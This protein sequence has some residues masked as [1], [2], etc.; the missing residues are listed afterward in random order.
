MA[1][2]WLYLAKGGRIDAGDNARMAEIL[3]E[4]SQ[5]TLRML[6]RTD[7]NP[8][9]EAVPGIDPK[10]SYGRRISK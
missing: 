10:Q 9:L 4:K 8:P 7:A 6:I 1:N 3:D 2:P 5:K